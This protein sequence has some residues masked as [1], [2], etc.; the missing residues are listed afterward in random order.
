MEEKSRESYAYL[1]APSDEMKKIKDLKETAVK[2]N[3][4]GA[5]EMSQCS[6][7][8]VALTEDHGLVPSTQMAAHKHLLIPVPGY[9]ML[10]SGLHR[11]Q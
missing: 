10:F 11:H 7:S 8:P 6:M 1:A 9:P 5:R 4:S 3:V 2:I